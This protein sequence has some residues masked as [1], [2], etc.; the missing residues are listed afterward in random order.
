MKAQFDLVSLQGDQIGRFFTKWAT[1]ESW[2]DL[3]FLQGDNF[4]RYF[5]K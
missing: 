2:F 4:E 3:V 5:I 1:F